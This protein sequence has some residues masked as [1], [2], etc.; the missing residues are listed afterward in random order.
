[1]KKHISI[2]LAAV[3]LCLLTINATAQNK[4]PNSQNTAG[5]VAL[6]IGTLG[7]TAIASAI[8]Y[9]QYIESLELQA[10]ELYL[11][12][13]KESDIFKVKLLSDQLNSM[14]DLSSTSVLAFGITEYE[15]QGIF[16]VKPKYRLM[17]MLLSQ[18][19]ANEYGINFSFVTTKVLDQNKWNTLY[20][21]YLNS[22][23]YP[24]FKNESEIKGYIKVSQK[25][26]NETN[27][28]K[29]ILRSAYGVEEYL[30]DA[31][32]SIPISSNIKLKSDAIILEQISQ[33]GY[34]INTYFLASRI[35]LDGDT[36]IRSNFDSDISIIFNEN[37]LGIYDNN[38][39]NLVQ[40]KNKGITS[41]HT[42]IN[43]VQ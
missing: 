41:I 21:N 14:K 26:Y 15:S 17:I 43:Q 18:G 13:Y 12:S 10:T 9:E 5:A 6:S 2:G 39:N 36:Y 29:I 34:T 22:I 20:F 31:N 25:K 28:D 11:K 30:V 37:K 27:G 38:L 24:K 1:M 40:I 35:R 3:Y 4:T 23:A 32:I 8:A 42:F 19:W 33:D 16:L 7:I